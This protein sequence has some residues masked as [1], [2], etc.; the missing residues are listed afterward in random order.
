[1]TDCQEE[2]STEL[3]RPHQ[4]CAERHDAALN[5]FGVNASPLLAVWRS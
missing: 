2:S 1:M 3:L 4:A 5:C